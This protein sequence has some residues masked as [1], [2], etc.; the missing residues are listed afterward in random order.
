MFF[1]LF[2]FLSYFLSF[3]TGRTPLH[4]ASSKGDI[5]LARLLLEA[6]ANVNAQDEVNIFFLLI[7]FYFS[8][9]LLIFFFFFSSGWTNSYFYRFSQR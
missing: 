2:S 6:N 8:Y 7:F 3:K 1:I 4:T 5:N 9:H